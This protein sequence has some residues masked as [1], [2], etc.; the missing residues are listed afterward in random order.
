[1][2]SEVVPGDVVELLDIQGE[3]VGRMMVKRPG[4]AKGEGKEEEAEGSPKRQRTE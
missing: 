1:M 2:C 3:C 4:D